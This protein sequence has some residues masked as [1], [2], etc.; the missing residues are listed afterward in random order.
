MFFLEAEVILK[1]A[2]EV[3]KLFTVPVKGEM[4]MS[5]YQYGKIVTWM[6]YYEISQ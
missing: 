6:P 4:S 5:Q 3:A 1:K 2:E